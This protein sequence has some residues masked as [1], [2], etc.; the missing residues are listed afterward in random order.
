MA[1]NTGKASKRVV[2]VGAGFAGLSCAKVLAGTSIPVTVIDSENYHVFV[3]LLYQVAT[4]TLSPGD[5]AASVRGILRRGRNIEV[6]LGEVVNV[7][8][9]ARKVLLKDG[10]PVSYDRLVIATGCRHDYAGHGDWAEQAPGIKTINDARRVRARLL[11]SFERAETTDDPE[12]KRAWMTIVIV[13]GGPTGVEMAGAIADLTHK[14]LAGEFRHIDPSKARIMLLEMG[15]RLLAGFPKQLSDY[16]AKRLKDLDVEVRLGQGVDSIEAEGIRIDG[17][18]VPAMTKIWAAG[19][20]PSPAA[21]WLGAD[22]DDKGRVIVDETLAVKGFDR[23][24]VI[25]DTA[26]C[27]D[28]NGDPLPGLAQVAKQQGHHL[29]KAIAASVKTGR[30]MPPFRFHNRGNVAVIGRNAAAVDFGKMRFKGFGGW[31]IW[32]A[33]HIYM[34]VGFRNRIMITMQ[35]FWWYFGAQRGARLIMGDPVLKRRR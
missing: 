19:V 29:G 20:D 31:L 26:R 33:V 21:E 23:I 2:I 5:I 30:K 32:A 10:P 11:K 34:L 6:C 17:E 24:Y 18:F 35:W 4:A 8:V 28:G 7:D 1:A 22:A 3:P 13:G 9:K 15:D 14:T 25:G 27:D 12:E 16:A